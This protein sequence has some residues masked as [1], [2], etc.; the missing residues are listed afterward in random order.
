[1]DNNYIKNLAYSLGADVCGIAS[2]DRFYDAPK[3]FSPIDI[4]G[5]AK[6]V[7]VYGK[8]FSKEMYETNTNAPYTFIKNKLVQDLDNISIEL[9]FRISAQGYGAIP[10]P[11][12]EPY[13]YWDEENKIGRGILSLKH[14]A[15]AAGIGFM[16]RNTLLINEKYGNRLYLAALV[17]NAELQADELLNKTCPKECDKCVKACPQYALDG[18]SINQKKCREKCISTTPGGGFV[19]GCNICRKICPFSRV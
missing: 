4:Y 18:I 3:G 19:Y 6:A 14:A 7:V 15:Q 17:T 11:G 9:S 8:H 12:D 1:M 2:I 10:I 13:D 16:G 5:E